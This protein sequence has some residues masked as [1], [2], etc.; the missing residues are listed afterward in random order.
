MRIGLSRWLKMTKEERDRA[1]ATPG[2]YIDISDVD[3]EPA[4]QAAG[5][6]PAEEYLGEATDVDH[7]GFNK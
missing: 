4:G 2:A 6:D 1:I 5:R 7:R 3:E